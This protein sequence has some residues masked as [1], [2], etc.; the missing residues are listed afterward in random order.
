[1]S[2]RAEAGKLA[3]SAAACVLATACAGADAPPRRA[4]AA[5]VCPVHKD[6]GVTQIDIFD[7]DP[8]GLAFLAPDD[9]RDGQGIYTVKDIYAKGRIVTVRCHYG[10]SVAEDVRLTQPVARCVFSGGD[11]HPRLD[12]K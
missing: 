11:A 3:A 6:A 1:M 9:E 4:A 7:G 5:G 8:A 2:W 12:C 10:G